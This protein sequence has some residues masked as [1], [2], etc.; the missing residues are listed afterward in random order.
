MAAVTICSDFGTQK[1]KVSHCFPIYLPWSDGPDAMILVFWMLSFNPTF[2]LSSFTFINRLFSSSLSAIKVVSSAYLRLLIFL[3]AILIQACASSHP[4]FLMM[5][6]AYMLN[7]QGDNIQSWCAPFPIWDQLVVLCPVLI[8]TCIQVSQEAG[9]VVW[10]SHLFQNFPQFVV[11]HTV[12][13]FGIVNKA[14]IDVFF[15]TLAFLMIQQ[16]LAIWPVVPLPFLN[17]AWTSVSWWFTYC[18]SLAWR[19]VSI[20]LL[21]CEMSAIVQ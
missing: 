12:K 21:A 15:G 9:Q 18:W 7:K 4:T 8:L 5:Y 2:S 13:G 10:Y 14:E 3:P 19:I 6:S 20:T 16:M 11:I 17:P 1:N